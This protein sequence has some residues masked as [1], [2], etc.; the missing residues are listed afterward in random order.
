M[1]AIK[2][3]GSQE[4][5]VKQQQFKMKRPL[6]ASSYETCKCSARVS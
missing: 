1:F 3:I 4:T 5:S 2:V 6:T